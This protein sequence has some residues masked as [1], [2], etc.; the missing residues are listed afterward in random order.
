MKHLPKILILLFLAIISCKNEENE[1][2]QIE[3]LNHW[4]DSINALYFDVPIQFDSIRKTDENRV[5]VY[6]YSN[7][8]EQYLLIDHEDT[9]VKMITIKQPDITIT[10]EYCVAGKN[11][12]RFERIM[13]NG[14]IHG[15]QLEINCHEQSKRIDY[16]LEGVKL[17]MQ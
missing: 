11:D 8:A 3:R 17:E 16:Y 6:S 15:R 10:R 14:K 2:T 13:F 7:N 5:R 1:L 4:T 12:K 9:L